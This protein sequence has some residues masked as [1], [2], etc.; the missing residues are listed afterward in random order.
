MKKKFSGLKQHTCITFS[1]CGLAI[2]VQLSWVLWF[3]LWERYS[4]LQVHL[5]GGGRNLHPES[6]TWFLAGCGCLLDW[7]IQFLAGY[8]LDISLSSLLC[9]L[10]NRAAHMA[11][12]FPW[13]KEA[14]EQKRSSK[15]EARI[16]LESPLLLPYSVFWRQ[17]SP[18]WRLG[19]YTKV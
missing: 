2:W 10:L 18:H 16:F 5:G 3:R 14:R 6:L 15:W 11:A 1:V 9:R 12:G 4:Y 19:S 17:S 8:W 7:G 13:S